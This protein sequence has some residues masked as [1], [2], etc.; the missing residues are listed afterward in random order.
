MK[1]HAFK[2]KNKKLSLSFCFKFKLSEYDD[3]CTSLD[4]RISLQNEKAVNT[5]DQGLLSKCA[6]MLVKN[7]NASNSKFDIIFYAVNRP[8]PGLFKLFLD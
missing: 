2:Y 7:Y 6:K 1:R 8:G 5:I 3:S 4:M